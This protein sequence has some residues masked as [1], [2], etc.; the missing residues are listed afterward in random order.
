MTVSACDPKVS[1]ERAETT[2]RAALDILKLFFGS[3][4]G[5]GLR[6]GHDRGYSE[7]T[8]S[9]TRGPD[10]TF[11]HSIGQRGEGALLNAGW[12]SAWRRTMHGF[13]RLQAARLKVIIP[14]NKSDHRDR[15]LDALNW[16]GQAVSERLPSAQLVKYVAALERLT[17]TAEDHTNEDHREEV[18]DIVTRRTALLAV[19]SYEPNLLKQA[20]ENARKLYRWR[21]D[22]MHG[23]SSPLSKEISSVIYLA[24]EIVQEAILGLLNILLKLK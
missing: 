2:V 22:L 14:G 17:V 4:N 16:Y 15:W 6:L 24:S 19:Q 21:L 3:Y 13:F 23:R 10:G 18:T 5:R 7:R 9:L 12:Y 8:A 20:R 11:R 1:G